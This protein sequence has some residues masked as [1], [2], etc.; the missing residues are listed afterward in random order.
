MKLLTAVAAAALG[1]GTLLAPMAAGATQIHAS[2][3]AWVAE[4]QKAQPTPPAPEEL[5]EEPLVARQG[6]QDDGV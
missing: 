2:R 3:T 6:I 4:I 5:E 1:I